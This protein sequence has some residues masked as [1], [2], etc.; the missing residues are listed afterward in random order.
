M[1]N[2]VFCAVRVPCDDGECI[3][4]AI[5]CNMEQKWAQDGMKMVLWYG[6]ETTSTQKVPE[7]I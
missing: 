4:A 7:Y 1:E 2:F 6:M 5:Y 3:K